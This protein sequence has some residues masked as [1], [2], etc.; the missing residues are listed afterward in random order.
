MSGGEMNTGRGELWV[1]GQ[2][3]LIAAIGIAPAFNRSPTALSLGLGV[4]ILLIG[5]VFGAAAMMTL[6]SSFTVYPKP[7]KEG[8][9]IQTGVYGLVRHPIYTSTILVLFGWS[10]IWVSIV[11]MLLTLVF[12]L[13]IDRKANQEEKWLTA[14][15]PDYPEYCQHVHK[16]IPWLY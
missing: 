13:Y 6:G 2:A 1:G 10:L 14:K 8:A 3:L 12:A 16:L 4:V 5:I 9:L 15:Y 11:G 7:I